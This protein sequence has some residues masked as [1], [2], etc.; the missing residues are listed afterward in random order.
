VEFLWDELK[1]TGNNALAYNK[2]LKKFFWDERKLSC[3]SAGYHDAERA[4]SLED[5]DYFRL[6]LLQRNIRR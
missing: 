4:D 1:K 2:I 5:N 3:N 6:I